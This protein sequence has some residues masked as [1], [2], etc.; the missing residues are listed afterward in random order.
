MKLLKLIF[1][2]VCSVTLLSWNQSVLADDGQWGTEDSPLIV[3]WIG[4]GSELDLE[5]FDAD[6]WKGWATLYVKNWCGA[7]W[8]DFHLKI[9]GYNIANVDFSETVAPQLWVKQGYSWVQ[10]TVNWEVDNVVV[11]AELDMTF[12]GSPITHGETAMIRVYTDN[13]YSH[14]SSFRI[15]AYPTP[16]PEPTIG[17]LLGLGLLGFLLRRKV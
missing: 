9:N 3:D 1:A 4:S 5:H 7:D 14:C 8:G 12:Y 17:G 13:T 2:V 10:E 16:V 11:G 15:C 6:P